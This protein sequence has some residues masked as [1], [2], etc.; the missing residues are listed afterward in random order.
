MGTRVQANPMN[1]LSL[2]AGADL[3]SSQ[4][5]AVQ[6]DADPREVKVAGSPAAEGTHVLGVL[7]NKPTEGQAASIA[8]ASVVWAI[9]LVLRTN[10]YYFQLS[11][12]S[13]SGT[14]HCI[15][16]DCQRRM[17]TTDFLVFFAT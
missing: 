17:V 13:S 3:S 11:S 14:S 16:S 7:Q 9:F 15:A 2:V 10:K 5:Y 1:V 4:Y 8:T 12:F 6:I